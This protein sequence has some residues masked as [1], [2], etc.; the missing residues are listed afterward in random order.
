MHPAG[1]AAAAAAGT[2][3]L[4]KWPSKRRIPVS[5]PGMADPHQL[6][7]DT[8]STQSRGY[9]AQRAPGGLGYPA[10]SA[11]PQAAFLADPVSNMAMAYGSSLAAQ[12]KEL[13]DKNI[14]RFIPV[15]KLKYYFAV[16][17][18]YVGRKLGLLFFPYLHQDWEVQYQQD[19]PVAPRFDVNAPDLYIPAMAFITYVLVAGLALGT[20]DRFSPDLLGLQASSALAWLTLEVVAILLSLY[21]V[22]VNTDL[23]T[24]D[25]V[26]FLGYKMIGGVLMGLLFGKIGYYLVLG[27]CCVA[28]FVFMIRTLRLKILAEAAAEG[29]PVRGAR[30]QLRMYLTMA[31]AAA[32]P[33][34]MYWLTF[35]LVR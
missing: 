8:S 20:Q 13:V 33:L 28:I 19:T 5:Q 32:Q 35:H 4:R 23:T 34:L 21:L 14:D 17:T 27:W 29:V 3:R 7:D 9:G 25:L 22:T 31:V 10:A 24:I 30:N 16:D 15:T 1:L 6:F 12:G 2:P 11:T 18:M 26:A